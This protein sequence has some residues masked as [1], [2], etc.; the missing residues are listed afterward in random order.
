MRRHVVLPQPEGPTSAT[1]SRSRTSNET[2]SSVRKSLPSRWNARVTSRKTMS[3]IDLLLS[4]S[5]VRERVGVRVSWS[6][7]DL[8]G[9]GAAFVQVAKRGAPVRQCAFLHPREVA[10]RAGVQRTRRGAEIGRR[11]R[12]RADQRDLG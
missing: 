2:W 10:E 1:N 6:K 5:R 4:L 8:R 12:V 9:A 11:V 3:L 7:D